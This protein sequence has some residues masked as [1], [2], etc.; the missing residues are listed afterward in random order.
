MKFL[1]QTEQKM[2]ASDSEYESMG[3]WIYYAAAVVGAVIGLLAVGDSAIQGDFAISAFTRMALTTLGLGLCAFACVDSVIRIPNGKTAAKKAVYN[4][5]AIIV[6]MVVGAVAAIVVII[7]VGILLVFLI[8][9]GGL[10]GGFSSGSKSTDM[11]S[12]IHGDD[13]EVNYIRRDNGDGTYT[14]QSNR[15]IRTDGSYDD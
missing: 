12:V 4:C 9:S 13:G 10:K 11:P 8:L 6:A 2:F 3:A 7:V 1:V 5:L 14:T 15:R